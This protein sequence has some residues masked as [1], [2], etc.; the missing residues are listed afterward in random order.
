MSLCIGFASW[1]P[2]Q[3]H[4]TPRYNKKLAAARDADGKGNASSFKQQQQLIICNDNSISHTHDSDTAETAHETPSRAHSA[5]GVAVAVSGE[6][7]D[8]TVY[9]RHI[10]HNRRLKLT[11]ASRAHLYCT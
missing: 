2:N 9:G 11:H 1:P 8:R 4:H 10:L 3:N 5:Q 6:S 7:D